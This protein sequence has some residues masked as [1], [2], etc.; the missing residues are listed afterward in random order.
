MRGIAGVYGAQGPSG[1]A[2]GGGPWE[3]CG[4]VHNGGGAQISPEPLRSRVRITVVE[5]D[6]AGGIDRR[7]G[8]RQSDGLVPVCRIGGRN[9]GRASGWCVED[10]ANPGGAI[11][12]QEAPGY[13]VP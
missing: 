12:N 9:Q 1:V 6:A 13:G 4:A 8:G 3:R 10:L 5:A 11:G 2:D 7:N